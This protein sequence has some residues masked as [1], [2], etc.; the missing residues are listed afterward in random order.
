MKDA[1]F[2]LDRRSVLVPQY[3]NRSQNNPNSKFAF[4]RTSDPSQES[5]LIGMMKNLN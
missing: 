1:K 5:S 4:Y 3:N 2:K